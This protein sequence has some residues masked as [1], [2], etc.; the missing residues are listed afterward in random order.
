MTFPK[1]PIKWP[2]AGVVRFPRQTLV[3][4]PLESV[5]A[6]LHWR[7]MSSADFAAWCAAQVPAVDEAIV[8]LTDSD[9]SY[10]YFAGTMSIHVFAPGVVPADPPT[11]SRMNIEMEIGWTA[12]QAAAGFVA[13]FNRWVQYFRPQWPNITGMQAQLVTT[14]VPYASLLMPF[15]PRLVLVDNTEAPNNFITLSDFE[16]RDV[17]LAFSQIGPRKNMFQVIWPLDTPVQPPN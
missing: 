5:R 8:V 13:Q 12:E 1:V 7:G 4:A 16:G 17:P 9:V 2:R 15:G 11:R 6:E 10:F 14:P 3:P